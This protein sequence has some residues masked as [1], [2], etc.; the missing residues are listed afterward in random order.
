GDIEGTPCKIVE[1]H[2]I[3]AEAGAAPGTALR[4]SRGI[5]IACGEGAVAIDRLIPPNRAAM[6]GEAFAASFFAP[7]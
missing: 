3:S 4:L 1:V 7:R 5:A 2:P 6:S